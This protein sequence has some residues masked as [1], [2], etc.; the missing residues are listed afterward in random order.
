M[1]L[2]WATALELARDTEFVDQVNSENSDVAD[3][4]LNSKAAELNEKLKAM[5]TKA[6]ISNDEVKSLT[7]T[8]NDNRENFDGL[9][10]HYELEIQKLK[11]MVDTMATERGIDPERL[12]QIK[13]KQD[14]LTGITET[15][16]FL[17][18]HLTKI[19]DAAEIDDLRD[20]EI[21]NSINRLIDILQDWINSLHSAYADV[22]FPL[23]KKR[24]YSQSE[25]EESDVPA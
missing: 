15:G 23:T 1:E 12:R 18:K 2:P 17:G 7:K 6:K 11:D 3:Q 21:G 22:L 20:A 13:S 10:N 25:D 9:K 4:V 24:G 16:M 5:R 19:I 14:L 8:I